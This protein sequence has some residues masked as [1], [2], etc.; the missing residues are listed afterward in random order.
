[1]DLPMRL[2]W[3]IAIGIVLAGAILMV[4]S[5]LLQAVVI[6]TV[7]LLGWLSRKRRDK[8]STGK[9]FPSEE[10]WKATRARWLEERRR[11]AA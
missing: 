9:W 8:R 2:A 6:G 3:E 11:R 5:F 1:M 10:D 4:G 7:E